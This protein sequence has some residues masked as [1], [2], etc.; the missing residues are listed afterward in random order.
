MPANNNSTKQ[1]IK[2]N[3]EILSR[4]NSNFKDFLL[5]WPLFASSVA[6]D[7][8]SPRTACSETQVIL[9]FSAVDHVKNTT[10]EIE[11]QAIK[12]DQFHE[13][14]S[15]FLNM[16]IAPESIGILKKNNFDT[17]SMYASFHHWT[18]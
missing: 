17:E 15:Y 13:N 4:L 3:D 11:L 9:E 18:V 12:E 1:L 2:N 14:V 10:I 8:E 5:H 6:I 16:Y 7:V